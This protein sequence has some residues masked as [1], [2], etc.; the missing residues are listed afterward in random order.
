MSLNSASKLL[1]LILIAWSLVACNAT[2][3]GTEATEPVAQA[4]ASSVPTREPEPAPYFNLTSLDGD[5]VSLSDYD[6]EW[7][8][9]NFWATWCPPCIA[10]MP[11]LQSL[12]DRG[13]NVLGVNMVEPPED[14]RL[15]TELH[16]I[17]FPILME[18]DTN[19]VLDYQARSLPRT[20]IIAPDGTTALRIT[21]P[22]DGEQLDPWLAKH[23]VLQG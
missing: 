8:L 7:V 15:F 22:I 19:L 17:T 6:G 12:A 21:G 20:V 5:S 10:E 23:G 16:G 4:A 9:V 18:P 1:T 3:G 2:S 13:L 14:V 11:Y